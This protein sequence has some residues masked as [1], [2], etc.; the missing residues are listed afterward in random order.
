MSSS[1][2]ASEPARTEVSSAPT[3]NQPSPSAQEGVVQPGVAE[4]AAQI[5][6]QQA[7][8]AS[9]R[10]DIFRFVITLMTFLIVIWVLY[11][12]LIN[13]DTPTFKDP[14]GSVVDPFARAGT[15]VAVVAPFITLV[16]GYWFGSKGT[17]TANQQVAVAQQQLT[18]AA[19]RT[20]IANVRATVLAA[21][22]DPSNVSALIGQH[23]EAFGLVGLEKS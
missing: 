5:E 16:L 2:P 3:I 6:P 19:A 14:A 12:S 9:R 22:A 10:N 11:Y 13:I 21:A 8:P 15:L 4:S 18:H 17:E 7:A 1:E 20:D 23:P